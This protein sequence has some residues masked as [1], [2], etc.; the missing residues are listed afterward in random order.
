MLHRFIQFHPVGSEVWS[1][2]LSGL[3]VDVGGG[4]VLLLVDL[5]A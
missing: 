5:V 4:V 2:V 3:L 1:L